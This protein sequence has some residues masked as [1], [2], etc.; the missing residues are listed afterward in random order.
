LIFEIFILYLCRYP[1]K[2]RGDK[3]INIYMSNTKISEIKMGVSIFLRLIHFVVIVEQG[4]G[5]KRK[6]VIA[7]IIILIS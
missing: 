6:K 1:P 2:C 5:L 3:D 7:L 4:Y